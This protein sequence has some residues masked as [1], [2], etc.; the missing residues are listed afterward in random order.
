[1]RRLWR[2]VLVLAIAS[3]VLAVS[4][5]RPLGNLLWPEPAIERLLERA[6]LALRAGR[7]TAADGSGAL[8]LYQ[9][10]LA[11][12]SDRSQARAGLAATGQAALQQA[13]AALAR[14]DVGAAGAALQLA[15]RL[16]MPRAQVQQVAVALAAHRQREADLRILPLLQAANEALVAGRL[17]G[18]P[19]SALPL[20]DQVLALDPNQIRALEGREDALTDLL[21]RARDA[22]PAGD[23]AMAAQLIAAGRVYDAGHVDLPQTE[24]AFNASMEQAL[25]QAEADLRRH[26]SHAALVRW[27]KVLDAVPEQ[28]RAREGIAQL[29]ALHAAQAV[30]L[31]GD[32]HFVDAQRALDV[33]EDIDPRAPGIDDARQAITAGR[34]AQA[35]LR[36]PAAADLEPRLQAHLQ[37][38]VRAGARQQWLAPPGESAFDALRAAQALAPKDARVIAAQRELVP[39]LRGCYDEALPRNRVRGAGECLQAWQSLSPADPALVTAR[40]RLA[41]RWIAVGSERL[42]AGDMA[43]AREAVTQAQ[44]LEPQLPEAQQ[45]AARLRDMA[46]RGG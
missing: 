41:Q 29:A 20:F 30:R 10:A 23:L 42:G 6:D 22:L 32:F 25:Q 27:R 34:R 31:A 43:F 5:Q 15:E 45:L 11:L 33:A 26:R 9:A 17:D 24:A 38:F 28:P 18:D 39:Q 1:M 14:G 3:I 37:Q 7:L 44:L 16:Q 8:E 40:R 46:P 12:D 13:R 2:W 19:R 35:A 36:T 21:Q 4:F